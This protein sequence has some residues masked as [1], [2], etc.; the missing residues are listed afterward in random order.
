MTSVKR[1]INHPKHLSKTCAVLLGASAKNKGVQPLLDAII[2]YLPSPTE[3]N[4]V[5]SV[6]DPKQ[7]RKPVKNERLCAYIFKIIYD[8]EKGP[9]SYARVYSGTLHRSTAL[10]NTTK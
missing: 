5:K 6:E 10:R 4:P 2:N 7:V 9:L 1:V 8:K 3:G